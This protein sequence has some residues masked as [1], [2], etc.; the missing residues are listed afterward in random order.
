MD[1]ETNHVERM[2]QAND[3]LSNPLFKEVFDNLRSDIMRDWSQTNPYDLDGREALYKYLKVIDSVEVR[4]KQAFMQ[5]ESA[6]AMQKQDKESEI[7]D[8]I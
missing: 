5:S 4:I 7:I 8:V 3:I 6:L 1:N 2:K